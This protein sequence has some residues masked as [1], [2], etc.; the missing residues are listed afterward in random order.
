MIEEKVTIPNPT[1]LHTRP[2]KNFVAEAKKFECD[3]TIS[4]KDK[5][6]SAKSLLK[7]MKMGISQNATIGLSC[8]GSDEA[9]AAAALKTFLENLE[10]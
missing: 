3:I 2:A 4:Y 7:L 9:E 8:E 5:E 1:G 6:A 10:D